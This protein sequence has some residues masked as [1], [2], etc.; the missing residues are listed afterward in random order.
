M[1]DHLRTDDFFDVASHPTATVRVHSARRA[2][3]T[4]EGLPLFSARFD[5]DLHGA[6]ETLDGEVTLVSEV[7]VVFEGS[8][9]LDRTRFGIGDP[10]SRWNPMSIRA[11]VPVRF[12]Y[13]P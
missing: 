7:P 12:R 10:P 4:P 8:L 6:Q 9:V 11:E 13:E 5:V 1:A 2:G 3:T